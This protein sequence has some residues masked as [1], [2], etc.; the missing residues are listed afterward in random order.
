MKKL[1]SILIIVVIIFVLGCVANY[2]DTARVST[3]HEPEL[4]LKTY[5]EKYD[6]VIYWGLGYKVV[7]YVNIS[8]Q[9]PYEDSINVKMGSWFMPYE[10]QITD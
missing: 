1:I 8:F 7:R 4:V 2:Y 6:A 3:G 10:K 5:S 9:E